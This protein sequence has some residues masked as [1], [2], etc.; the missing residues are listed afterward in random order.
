MRSQRGERLARP[1]S[2]AALKEAYTPYSLPITQVA[3]AASCSLGRHSGQKRDTINTRRL[4]SIGLRNQTRDSRFSHFDYTPINRKAQR[5]DFTNSRII[6]TDR[7]PHISLDRN[8]SLE[9]GY[10]FNNR[11]T[12]TPMTNAMTYCSSS[13]FWP[14]IQIGS[15]PVGYQEEGRRE[16]ARIARVNS[17]HDIASLRPNS[18]HHGIKRLPGQRTIT[19][20]FSTSDQLQ[21][22]PFKLA[23]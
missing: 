16:S 9:T 2:L 7:H 6:V 11:N 3:L 15:L 22:A 12:N 20:R 10:P 1:H 18:V 14:S 8:I 13:G 4:P 21:V 23:C 17:A 19:R 5:S